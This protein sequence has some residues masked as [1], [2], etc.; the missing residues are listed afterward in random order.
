[1]AALIKRGSLRASETVIPATA[2]AQVWRGGPRSSRLARLVASATVD[3][4]GEERAKEVGSRLGARGTTDIADAHVV[5]CAVELEGTAVSSD[6][7]DL[8]A[9]VE[10]G[11]P[12]ALIDV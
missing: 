5:C 4:L 3:E 11:E 12:L 1:M 2:L 7:D 6:P 10:P 8:R 9:L